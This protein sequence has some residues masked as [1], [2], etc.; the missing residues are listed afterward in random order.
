MTSKSLTSALGR[1]M[2]FGLIGC[3]FGCRS[4]DRTVPAGVAP[5]ASRST[6]LPADHL[7]PGELAPGKEVVFGFVVPTAMRVER[8]FPDAAHLIGHVDPQAL[9]RYVRAHVEVQ[10]MEMGGARVIFPAAIIPGAPKDHT[11]RVEILSDRLQTRMVLRD[12]T[13]PPTPRGLSEE[14]RWRRAGRAMDGGML[15]RQKLE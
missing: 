8:R 4:G 9:A 14:E 7:A 5:S 11:F 15:D 6:A 12:V 1:A 10:R 2:V 13:P 3:Q